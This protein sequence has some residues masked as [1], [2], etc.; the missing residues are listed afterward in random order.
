MLHQTVKEPEKTKEAATN[1]VTKLDEA[2]HLRLLLES[3]Q[4]VAKSVRTP[5][6]CIKIKQR[7]YTIISKRHVF[8]W[9]CVNMTRCDIVV[10]VHAIMT[11]HAIKTP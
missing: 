5:V 6:C 7:S 8:I 3:R 2:E 9:W 11:C 1:K 4:A 10:G